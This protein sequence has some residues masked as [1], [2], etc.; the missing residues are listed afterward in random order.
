MYKILEILENYF[1]LAAQ[2][3][4]FGIVGL[5]AA[6]IHISIVIA[7]VQHAQLVPLV[8]NAFAF[9]ISFQM[10]YW[11]HRLWTFNDTDTLHRTALPKL[12]I[13]QILNFI[14]NESLFYVFLSLNIPYPVA[15]VFVLTILPIFT[16]VSSKLWVF[17]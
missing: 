17:R 15:L 4:R 12:L 10:S 1:P 14:A 2:L 13:V 16:F 11:G 9:C 8:A 7:L 5:T 6:A 3:F